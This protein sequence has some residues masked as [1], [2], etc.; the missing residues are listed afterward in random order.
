MRRIWKL[1]E[2]TPSPFN[3]LFSQVCLLPD[4][5]VDWCSH[6]AARHRTI[7]RLHNRPQLQPLFAWVPLAFNS[8]PQIPR[9]GRTNIYVF[10]LKPERRKR[11]KTISSIRCQ[12]RHRSSLQNYQRRFFI[13][14][15]FGRGFRI[16][17]S[18]GCSRFLVARP[19][20]TLTLTSL[21]L[22]VLWP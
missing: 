4:I 1:W 13:P 5:S 3:S 14:I 21:G 17:L 19:P 8:S 11:S 2:S 9:V 10:T 15:V 6:S 12:Q 16:H 20:E 22:L 18:H 7:I